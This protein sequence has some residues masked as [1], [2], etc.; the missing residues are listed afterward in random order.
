MT[1]VNMK[2]KKSGLF[3][4]ALFVF[5][6]SFRYSAYHILL[7]SG[8]ISRETMLMI[9]IIGLTAGPAVSL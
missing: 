6:G 4:A 7:K 8:T 9:L 5:A 3:E 1:E 2:R